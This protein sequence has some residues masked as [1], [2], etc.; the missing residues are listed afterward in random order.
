MRH[1]AFAAFA[2]LF[3]A[4]S[5]G[6]A[7]AAAETGRFAYCSV[8]DTGGRT[9]WVSR[10]FPAPGR[11]D[12]LGTQ[13]ATEFHT[14]VGTLGGTGNKQCL[15]TLSR[16][17]A[18]ETRARI[19]AIMGKRVFG[20]RV[21]K[22]H[23]VQ[24]TPSAA[25]YADTAPA[26][27]VATPKFIYCRTVDT[28]KRILVASEIFVQTLPPLGDPVHLQELG[29]YAG[30]FGARAAATQSIA[31]GMP[32]CIASD[33]RPEADKSRNDFRKA[34]PFA[35]IH[36]VDLM[37]TPGSAPAAPSAPV[38]AAPATTAAAP[39]AG[40]ADEVEEDFWRRI[41]ASTTAEDFQDYLAAYPQGRHAPVARLE[42]KRLSR[43]GAKSATPAKAVSA[44]ATVAAGAA[45]NAPVADPAHPINAEVGRQ[46][47]SAAFFQLPAAGTGESARRVGTRIV[48]KTV[49]VT[50]DT[51][52]Q[53]VPGSNQCRLEMTSLAG[54][55]GAF[56]TAASGQSWAGFIPLSMRSR[57][58]S[59]YAN[60]DGV[61]SMVAIDKLVGQPFPLVAGNTFGF[62]T[63]FENVDNSTGTTRFGQDWSCRVGA[64]GP[65]SASIPG[66]A[67]E[68]TELQCH[69]GYVGLT[70]P[71]QDPVIVWYSAAG[72]FVQDP[73][74]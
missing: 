26:A 17:T 57:M 61:F 40:P 28:D 49:P 31:A 3:L 11:V 45:S 63:T 59:Q 37:W 38:V 53:R 72:C 46:I 34:F 5:V 23:D 35:G 50:L 62:T 65:A 25:T 7:Q 1:V 6:W 30:E 69:M 15:V 19:A 21:Y 68:Q 27:T 73:T 51:T 47:A 33:T 48:N 10:V 67:G 64:T 41:S 54:A 56:K 44:A 66:M 12:F 42:A 4:P 9:I 8:E 13:L 24:W 74:R 2:L 43:G 70:L 58:S 52:V 39:A 29:R 16:A 22:W 32:L 18:E 36:K 20:I 14:H 55:D 60:V 71:A